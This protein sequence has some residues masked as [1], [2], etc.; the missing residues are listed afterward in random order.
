MTYLFN[1]FARRSYACSWGAKFTNALIRKDCPGFE[2]LT[3][4]QIQTGRPDF[5]RQRGKPRGME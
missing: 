1:I 2:K 5:K 3:E 4:S